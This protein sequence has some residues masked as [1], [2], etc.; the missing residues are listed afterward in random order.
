ARFVDHLLRVCIGLRNIFLVT[1]LRLR[2]FLLD[3]FRVNLAFFDL[4]P[5][6][7]EYSKNWFVSETLQ[8]VCD[9]AEADD[10]RQ[11]Q[12]PIPAKRFG[13]IAQDISDASATRG[14]NHVHKLSLGCNIDCL[15]S[16]INERDRARRKQRA[17]AEGWREVCARAQGAWTR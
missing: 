5:T 15:H 4:A 12:F 16:E 2:E 11:K 9:D 7:L 13:C 10:L 14:N 3:F 8:K 6:L 17:R 1:L